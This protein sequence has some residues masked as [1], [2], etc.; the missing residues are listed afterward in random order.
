MLTLYKWAPEHSWQS[1]GMLYSS[2]EWVLPLDMEK[3]SWVQSTVVCQ[4]LFAQA[5]R[6]WARRK[7]KFHLLGEK[8]KSGMYMGN[9]TW[10][11]YN[12]LQSKPLLLK[13]I[14]LG[15]IKKCQTLSNLQLHTIDA[16]RK[17]YWG[18]WRRVHLDPKFNRGQGHWNYTR[19]TVTALNQEPTRRCFSWSSHKAEGLHTLLRDLLTWADGFWWR[20]HTWGWGLQRPSELQPDKPLCHQVPG[21]R[22]RASCFIAFAYMNRSFLR[23]PNIPPRLKRLKNP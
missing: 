16:V 11:V 7:W 9:M 3:S 6:W 20:C 14:I 17:D 12:I 10:G 23:L 2:S 18:H 15:R 5:Y 8:I 21:G 19:F 4:A 13:K 1:E 22:K